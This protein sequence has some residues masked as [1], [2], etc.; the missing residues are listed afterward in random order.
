[1]AGVSWQGTA[2]TI[3]M[4]LWAWAL[5]VI[6]GSGL[7][8]MLVTA[9]FRKE[10]SSSAVDGDQRAVQT[11][12]ILFAND[13][14]MARGIAKHPNSRW[15]RSWG[16]RMDLRQTRRKLA[17]SVRMPSGTRGGLIGRLQAIVALRPAKPTRRS[18]VALLF[19]SSGIRVKQ[20]LLS[21]ADVPSTRMSDYAGT[22][23]YEK[24]RSEYRRVTVGGTEGLAG[25]PASFK[26]RYDVIERRPGV[27][28]WYKKPLLLTVYGDGHIPLNRLIAVAQLFD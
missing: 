1:M 23:S 27:V 17:F 6:A 22:P 13:P 24:I 11:A 21:P 20:S 7:L 25:P 10:P 2:V 19:Y 28:T 15:W 12:A 3:R 9:P 8:V 4:P 5:F 14:F 18:I 26:N 16:Q